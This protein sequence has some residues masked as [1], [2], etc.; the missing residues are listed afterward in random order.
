MPS[1]IKSDCNPPT[2]AWQCPFRTK[3][4]TECRA[5]LRFKRKSAPDSG[6]FSV[7]NG[8]QNGSQGCFPFETGRFFSEKGDI[9][10]AFSVDMRKLFF[11]FPFETGRFFSEKGDIMIAFS[12]DMRKLFFYSVETFARNVSTTAGTATAASRPN[13]DFDKGACPLAD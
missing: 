13:C 12:V 11:Y 6:R 2:T 1:L 7:L 10:I 5:V 8:K 4:G 3:T 9:M